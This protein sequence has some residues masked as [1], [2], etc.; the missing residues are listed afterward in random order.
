MEKGLKVGYVSGPFAK[1]IPE[2]KAGD[3]V[4]SYTQFSMYLQCPRQWELAYARRLRKDR[5]GIATTFG[6]AMHRTIQDWLLV[7]YTKTAKEA[8]A[9]D[10][11]G[12]L[13]R[14]MSEKYAEEK[15]RNGDQHFTTKEVMFEHYE[16]GVNI[17]RYLR[18]ERSSY[19]NTRNMTLVGIEVP[20]YLTPVESRPTVYLMGY[21]DLVFY[22]KR[23]GSYL[24]LD[25]K[26]ST[27]GWNDW[28]KK[29]ETKTAQMLLYKRYLADQYG[30][31]INKIDVEYFILRR[32][33]D[34]SSMYPPK[35]VQTFKPAQG[36][37]SYNKVQRLFQEFVHDSFNPD[38]SYN[39]E[40]EYPALAGRPARTDG[41]CK[42]CRF[43]E[44]AGREDL[45]HPSAR[46]QDF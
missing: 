25:I 40:R 45:C 23:D 13:F 26:T 21:L 28:A 11:E 15:A 20:I 33:I 42:N 30:V 4:V 16:D 3:R 36:K 44:F 1:P 35:R 27:S 22:D 32:K 38:G 18:K 5:P 14:Y 24:I 7:A 6:D 37:P 31:D 17:L 41:V 8:E 19:F 46:K 29:D 2:K 9:M 12:M 39:L 43:C 10:L 34:T